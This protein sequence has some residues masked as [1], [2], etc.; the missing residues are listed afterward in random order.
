MRVLVC[1]PTVLADCRTV[2]SKLGIEAVAADCGQQITLPKN[3]NALIL[4]MNKAQAAVGYLLA[5][6][7][8]QNIPALCL[9]AKGSILPEPLNGLRLNN[10]FNRKIKL[11]RHTSK[12]LP[13][14]V[15]RFINS[16][17]Q[18]TEERATI[19]FTLRLTP[20]IEKY[21]GWKADQDH[22]D[23]A[24]FLRRHLADELMAND[25]AYLQFTGK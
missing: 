9:V 13:K 24:M 23:K 18:E 4:E 7:V 3:I 12:T 25:Q 15:E 19:K 22:I 11:V 10:Q 1:A 14:A 5:L 6:A 16:I 2:I 20:S 8:S 17:S 21:L